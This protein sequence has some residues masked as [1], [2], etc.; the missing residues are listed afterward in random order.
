MF[1]I[2]FCIVTKMSCSMQ[3]INDKIK[4][5]MNCQCISKK[6]NWF[7]KTWFLISKYYKYAIVLIYNFEQRFFN[8]LI[9]FIIEFIQNTY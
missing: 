7:D 9:A 8:S 1:T 4:V 5:E 2:K 6:K 3:I